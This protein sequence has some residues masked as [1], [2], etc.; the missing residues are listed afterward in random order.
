MLA[1]HFRLVSPLHRSHI[2]QSAELKQLRLNWG[3]IVLE[4]ADSSWELVQAV[5]LFELGALWLRAY[6]LLFWFLRV[7]RLDLRVRDVF[8]M[9][10]DVVEGGVAGGV[11]VFEGMIN[12]Y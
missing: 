2:L 4:V 5:K 10:G 3:Q 1:I 12:I 6:H 7:W 11:V 8:A 9:I